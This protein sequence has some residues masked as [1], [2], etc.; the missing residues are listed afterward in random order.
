M[1]KT[2]KEKTSL[3]LEEN[4]EGALCYV[5]AWITGLIFLILENKSKFVKFHALQSII[6]FLGLTVVAIFFN[7]IP[8]VGWVISALI[9]LLTFALWIILIIK[10]YQGEK[11]KL[12]IAG[13]I[14]E[15]HSK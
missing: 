8:V 10:S 12:P 5:L 13:D 14:A 1:K 3:G 11:Y 15:K 2:K 4:V 7:L 6:T 9:G